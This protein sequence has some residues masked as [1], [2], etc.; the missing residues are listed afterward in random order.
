MNKHEEKVWNEY[1]NKVEWYFSQEWSDKPYN[2]V[3]YGDSNQLA[4]EELS[5]KNVLLHEKAESIIR[6]SWNAGS[7]VQSAS[8]FL[9]MFFKKVGKFDQK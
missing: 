1:K 9:W 7:N 5:K 6:E 3:L 2:E 8:Y 4:S